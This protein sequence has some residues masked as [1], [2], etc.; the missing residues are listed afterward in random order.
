MEIIQKMLDNDEMDTLDMIYFQPKVGPNGESK[1]GNHIKL[2][3]GKSTAPEL[4]Y[5][6]IPFQSAL[7]L[8]YTLENNKVAFR[9]LR[10]LHKKW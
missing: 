10:L 2:G 3:K 1:F 5:S 4:C 6:R 9:G 8:I 7:D